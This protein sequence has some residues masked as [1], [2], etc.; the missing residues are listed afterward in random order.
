MTLSYLCF[1][2]LSI[3]RMQGWL[4]VLD[5]SFTKEIIIKTTA[6]LHRQLWSFIDLKY[7]H[8]LTKMPC[9]IFWWLKKCHSE[10]KWHESTHSILHYVPT[11]FKSLLHMPKHSTTLDR[12]FSSARVPTCSN[13]WHFFLND[14]PDMRFMDHH[15]C[16][17]I[18]IL[19]PGLHHY[20]GPDGLLLSILITHA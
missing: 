6:Y 14:T 17:N 7:Q 3:V 4:S 12:N 2:E 16:P 8:K 9:N 19:A 5:L 11:Q 1:T 20:I 18:A 15:A 13:F 10:D